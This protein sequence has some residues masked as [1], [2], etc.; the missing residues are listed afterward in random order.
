MAVFLMISTPVFRYFLLVR[1]SMWVI[2]TIQTSGVP[3]TR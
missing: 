3:V 2:V 1:Y